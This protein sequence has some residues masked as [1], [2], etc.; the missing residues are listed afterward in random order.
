[1]NSLHSELEAAVEAWDARGWPR[2][3]VWIVSGSGLAVDV[4]P[5]SSRDRIPLQE[6]LPFP[7]AAIEGHPLS[8]EILEGEHH[9]TVAYQRGRVHTYQGYDAA[10]TVFHVRLAALLGAETL[11]MTNAAGSLRPEVGPGKLVAVTDHLNLMGMNP[12]TGTLPESWGPLFPDMTETHDRELRSSATRIASDLG[13]TLGEGIYVG[14]PGPSY[15]TPAEIRMLATL[16]ADL[17]GMSTV[18]EVIA[19]GH[20]GLRCLCISMVS[21]HAAGIGEGVLEHEDVLEIGRTGSGRIRQLL[22]RLLATEPS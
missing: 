17:V 3:G 9:E 1:M 21:N 5:D 10:Q 19:A 7:L 11:I 6:I 14:V 18:L 4:L 13:F 15:E 8:V 16:G 22:E 2:P 20:M 12:L